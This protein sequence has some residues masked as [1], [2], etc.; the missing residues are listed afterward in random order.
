[1]AVGE[2]PGLHVKIS[3]DNKGLNS[4][5][6]ASGSNLDKFRD[7]VNV[8]AERLAKFTTAATIAGA[9]VAAFKLVGVTREFNKLNAGLIT[10]TGSAEKADIAFKA[11]QDF[12][13]KTPST[14]QD[15]TDAF[16]KLNNLGLQP[17]ERALTSYGNTASAMG[18][19]LM[20]FIEAVADASTS[21]F[22]R[23]KEFG[24]RAKNQGDTIAFTFRGVTST[25]ANNAAAI[26]EHLISLGETNFAGAMEQ[27]MATLDGALSNLG[28][29]WDKLFL[30]VSN[31]GVGSVIEEAARSAIV[32]VDELSA[33]IESGQLP[34]QIEAIGNKF[35][36]FAKDFIDLFDLMGD[37]AGNEFR[38]I[39]DVGVNTADLLTSAFTDFPE[40]MRAIIQL[41]GVEVGNLGN[42]F[43]NSAEFAVQAYTVKLLSLIDKSI[44]IGKAIA[45]GLNPFNSTTD[46]FAGIES[47]FKRIDQV[48]Q[49]TTDAFAAELDRELTA[50]SNAR[51]DSI[52][53]IVTERDAALASFDD[54]I[55]AAETLRAKFDEL[56]ANR[57]GAGGDALAQFGIKG[58]GGEGGGDFG[59][60]KAEKASIDDAQKALDALRQR[61]ATEAELLTKKSEDD[62]AILVESLMRGQLTKEE[63]QARELEIKASHEE[64]LTQI[65]DEASRARMLIT[66]AE[67]A[68]KKQAFN[69]MF[70]DLASLMNTGS[71]KMF[72][73]GKAAAIT[74][75]ILS[76]Y[77]GAQ[78]AFTALAGIPIVGP[79]LGAAAAG[80]AIA[81]GMA[82]VQA[83]NSTSFGS[84]SA[85][86]GGG[87]SAPSAA[88]T[89]AEQGATGGGSSRIISVQG[90]SPDTLISGRMLV[91]LLNQA[92][93]DG[94]RLVIS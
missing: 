45:D 84:K 73:I 23:L 42:V 26:E 49:D 93:E 37:K 16:I 83:I 87:L 9:S 74:Q 44:V 34:A 50:S 60:T 82:R 85:A 25:V 70:T 1:M 90:I 14:L 48:A 12:A 17:S 13:A 7:K 15:V 56:N 8:S 89:S 5:L 30:T 54:Q 33:Q 32:A 27:R 28:D 67:A 79:A 72:E 11:L 68:A 3:V 35:D 19:D 77:E 47:E 41:A 88:P 64:A 86:G 81:S 29:S 6:A 53:A 55:A 78:K 69:Q 46:I 18:K 57:L 22:E 2:L 40:N 94:A 59:P 52:M 38:F 65:E 80:A 58:A 51:R 20:Q 10:A 66:E 91:D 75:T 24:I 39:G 92:Q 31:A 4:G 62:Y 63:F 21:E 43:A 71:R 76:T 36:G 61:H